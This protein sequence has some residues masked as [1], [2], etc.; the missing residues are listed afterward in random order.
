MY[1]YQSTLKATHPFASPWYSWPFLFDIL[2]RNVH[3]P[4]WL[5]LASF[6]NGKES[7]IVLLGNPAAWWFGFAAI[8]GITGFS[9]SKIFRKGFNLKE[10]LPAIFII[11]FFFF[12]WLPYIVISRVVFI[13][14]FYVNVP[15]L[16]LGAAFVFDK[17]WDKEITKLI[18]VIFFALVV[19]VFVLFYPVIS[20]VPTST[21]TINHLK[22][23][24]SWVF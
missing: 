1:G 20:G 8:V 15:F 9:V 10:H 18:A 14:H 13:Y 3:I 12:Q 22:W 6:P 7:T 16:F 4:L 24:G 21:T 19:A 17:Y 5:Q 11:T 23:F 2:N